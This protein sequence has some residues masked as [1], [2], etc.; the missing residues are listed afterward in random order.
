MTNLPTL[1][2]TDRK[3]LEILSDNARMSNAELARRMGMAPSATFERIRK[4]EERGVILGYRARI[5]PRVLDLGLLAFVLVRSNETPG[6][7]DT[8]PQLARIPQVIEVH[9]VAG[10]DCFLLKVRARDPE[11]LANILREQIKPIPSVTH[12]RTTIVLLTVKES[13]ALP[14]AMEPETRVVEV[15][16]QRAG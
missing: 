12:T 2:Q 16:K 1:D 8:G 9:E 10:E 7:P 13:G 5:D 14:V 6:T 3:I 4:L 11:D 15:T